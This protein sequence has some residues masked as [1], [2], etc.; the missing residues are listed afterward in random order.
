MPS[1]RHY[2]TDFWLEM[3][4]MLNI[5]PKGRELY[6]TIQEK[7][8]EIISTGKPTYWPTDIHKT[9]D[10]LDFFIFKGLSHN[11]LDLRPNLEIASYHTPIIATISTHII[12]RQKP[13][14]LHNSQT[15]WEAFR[16]KIEEN[17]RLNIP[18][19]TVKDIEEAIAEFTNVIQKGA[20]SAIPHDKPQTKYSEYPWEVRD[21]INERKLRRRW[22]MSRHPEDKRRYNEVARKLKDRIKR[23]KEET[24]QTYLQVTLTVT[25]DT[26]YSL[27]KA[28]KRLKLPQRIPPIRN[29]DQTWARSD[30]EKGNTSAGHL[31]E[32]FKPNDLP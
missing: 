1:L 2:D 7:Q 32:T 29:A 21:Q 27:W 31:E 4:S 24:F 22:Q 14:K 19:E 18:L 9:P 25:A 23:I 30:K 8:L 12:T 20:W 3:I 28:T 16:N 17:L 10:L 6:Q 26:D 11:S 5:N 15:N 13:L